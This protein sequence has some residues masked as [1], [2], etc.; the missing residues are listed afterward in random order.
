MPWESLQIFSRIHLCFLEIDQ[1]FEP[2]ILS[3]TEP[4]ST[5]GNGSDPSS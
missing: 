5:K 1:F 4:G 2:N 3:A